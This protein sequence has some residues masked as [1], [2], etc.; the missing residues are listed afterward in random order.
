MNLI[1]LIAYIDPAS[2]SVIF[3]VLLA[4]ILGFFV[5]IRKIKA[6]VINFFNKFKRDR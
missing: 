6:V 1:A 5:Y 2:G 4:A 3:Q